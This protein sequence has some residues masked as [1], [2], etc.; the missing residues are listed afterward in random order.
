[1]EVVNTT[2]TTDPVNMYNYLNSF[3][4]NPMVFIIIL[5]IIV[6]FYVFSSSLDIPIINSSLQNRSFY[7]NISIINTTGSVFSYQ[8]ALK[9]QTIS[10]INLQ[11]CNAT[12]NVPYINFSVV[13]EKTGVNLNSTF[14]STFSYWLGQGVI[15]KNVSV[16][17][18]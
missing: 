12:Y 13:D 9:N 1:M 6:A 15:K 7:W 11:I 3:I 18:L 17:D 5:L 10:R 2:S 4:L 14:Q 8:S 16:N